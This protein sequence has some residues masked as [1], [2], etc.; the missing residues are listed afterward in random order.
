VIDWEGCENINDADMIRVLRA[1]EQKGMKDILTME[2]PWNDEV[3]T[4]FY[5]TLWIKKVDEEADAY[6]HPVMYFYL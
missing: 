4:Q 1:C 2:H 6:D 3:I 5:A